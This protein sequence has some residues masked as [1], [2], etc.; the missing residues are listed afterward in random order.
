MCALCS[1]VGSWSH[2]LIQSVNRLY[3]MPNK[4]IQLVLPV[5]ASSYVRDLIIALRAADAT[6]DIAVSSLPQ[7]P[8][9]RY[10]S[11]KFVEAIEGSASHVLSNPYSFGVSIVRHADKLGIQ[12]C[13]MINAAGLVVR[14]SHGSISA[15]LNELGVSSTELDRVTGKPII[16]WTASLS[17][18]LGPNAWPLI[19]TTSVLFHK[20]YSRTTCRARSELAKFVRWMLHSE[21]VYYT[22]AVSESAAML[23][24]EMSEQ[25]GLES[26][27]INVMRC[28][29]S[30][31]PINADMPFPITVGGGAAASL[32]NSLRETLLQ[33]YFSKVSDAT[34]VSE[35]MNEKDALHGLLNPVAK[36]DFGTSAHAL[37]QSH[38][39][40]EHPTHRSERIEA[41]TSL[42]CVCDVTE[43]APHPVIVT[44]SSFVSHQ[45]PGSSPR[46]TAASTQET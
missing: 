35:K 16:R 39:P 5:R 17:Y 12:P 9:D 20:R 37:A 14:P 34:F 6:L 26:A 33:A 42:E 31:S 41:W 32:H 38:T 2:P 13:R 29:D 7:W 46:P 45:Q 18:A 11:Y 40:I 23:P 19:S 22:L 1:N 28:G 27:L 10:A 24:H 15:A 43:M 8:L 4:P 30:A 25:L 36:P 3:K 21:S 44:F